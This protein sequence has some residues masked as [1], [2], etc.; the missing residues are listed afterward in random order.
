MSDAGDGKKNLGK[1]VKL[2]SLVLASVLGLFVLVF[3]ALHAYLASPLSAPQ[4]SRFVTSYLRQELIVKEV[5]LSGRTLI[6]K[7]V[8]L[9]NPAGFTGGDLF[10]ADQVAIAPLWADLVRG[11]QRF[12]LVSVDGGKVN[13]EKNSG[14]V[15]NFAELKRRLAARKPPPPKE[16]PAPETVIR[17]LLVRNGTITV[18]GQGVRGINLQVFNLATGGSRDAQVELAFE[19]ATRN[20]YLLKGAARPGKDPAVDLSLTAAAL[21]LKDLATLLKLKDVELFRDARGALQADAVLAKGELRGSGSFSFAGVRIP[22][23]S[24]DY[25]VAGTLQANGSY[26]LAED[27]VYLN[28]ATLTIDKMARLQAEGSIRG[29]KTERAFALLLGLD[30]VDLALVNVLLPEESRKELL[31][32]GTLRCE[33]LRLEGSAGSGLETAVGILQLKD[34]SLAREGELLAGGISGDLTLSRKGRAVSAKGRFSIP[35]PYPKALVE[36]LDLPFNATLSAQLK[37]LRARSGALSARIM[38]VPIAGRASYDAGSTEALSASLKIPSTQLARLNPVLERHGVQAS[39]GTVSATLDLTGTGGQDLAASA[40]LQLSNLKGKRGKDTFGVKAAAVTATLQKRGELLQ[41]KGDARL[42]ALSLNGKS[43]DA[44]FAYRLA[45]RMVHLDGVRAGLGDTRLSASRL[46]ARVTEQVREPKGTRYPL[47]VDM[48]GGAV[49]QGEL[50]LAN[51]T[52]RARGSLVSQGTEKWLEG[53][54]DLASRALSWRG[55]GVAAPVLHFTFA[56]AGARGELS[57]ELMGGKVA[58]RA[59][60]RPFAPEAG[61]TFKLDLTGAAA[62]QAAG[63]LPATSAMRPTGGRIDLQLSGAYSGRDGLTS[64]FDAT[65]RGISLADA[66][67]KSMLSGATLSLAGR[68]SREMLSITQ[69]SLAPGP[70]VALQVKGEVANPFTEKR[71]G[72]L[73]FSLPESS[74]NALVES[75]IN[76]VPATVQEATLSGTVAAKG[77]LELRE[78]RKLLEGGVTV[79]GGKMEVAPQKLVVAGINGTLPISLDLAGKTGAKPRDGNEFSRQNYPRLLAKLRG[80]RPGGEVVTVGKITYGTLE[81]GETTVNLRASNGLMEISS[82]RTTLYDGSLLGTGYL[83]LGA[84]TSYRGDLLVNGVSMRTLCRTIPNLEGYISGRVDGVISVRGVGGGVKGIAGFLDLWAREGGGE[85]MLVS[86]EFLQRLAKQKLSGFFL[87]RDRPYDMAEIKGTL[88]GGDLT[89]NSLKIL[90][91]NVFGVRDLNVTIA[92]TQNRIALDHLLASIKEATARG[93]PAAGEKPPAK[94]PGKP[95]GVPEF[96]W[97]E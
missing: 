39:S 59:A 50:Q 69:A 79:K 31:F 37:P 44:R 57:G 56:R 28:E 90:N 22:A 67:G 40:R 34:G 2:L 45:D 9:K 64:R 53:T 95:E 52:G 85:K 4:L 86:K 87:G 81:L 15:W 48:E 89:F 72:A 41:A 83:A 25:P 30:A 77:R 73:A 54:A 51:L 58:G 23:A 71:R 38:G 61:A 65:G 6:L 63:L 76:L 36:A 11:R 47:F 68:L 60:F 42:A 26:S 88:E 10:A 46:S 35:R 97:E 32:G 16:A 75:L 55:R 80:L 12:H 96:K 27:T 94:G 29:V 1:S 5:Q 78:G 19:D 93:T 49:R 91:T 14:G 8:R 43:G 62:E 20:R 21:S 24:G 17:K 13:L 92:P 70:D 74:L 7:G 82:L 18:Q 3:L 84:K 66:S 33:S